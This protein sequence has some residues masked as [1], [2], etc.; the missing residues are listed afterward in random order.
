MQRYSN[1]TTAFSFSQSL[2]DITAM[3]PEFLQPLLLLSYRIPSSRIASLHAPSTAPQLYGKGPKDVLFVIFW[4]VAFTTLREVLA[5]FVC[6]PFARRWISSDAD[7]K[8]KG[9]LSKKEKRRQQHVVTRFSE[10]GWSF[11]YYV[12]FWSF[13]MVSR[14][15]QE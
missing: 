11:F 9:G 4:A 7:G 8:T 13:G 12:V 15:G 10:Q 1:M 14:V 6:G 5:R 3:V 2:P